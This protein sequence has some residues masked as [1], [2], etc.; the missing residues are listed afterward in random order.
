MVRGII[1][2]GAVVIDHVY[3]ALCGR[4]AF[5][6][7]VVLSLGGS[8]RKEALRYDARCAMVEYAHVSKMSF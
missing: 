1:C 3:V 6:W 5:V 7:I 8:S 2:D 4:K